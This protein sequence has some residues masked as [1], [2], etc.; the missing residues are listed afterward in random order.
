MNGDYVNGRRIEEKERKF[1]LLCVCVCVCERMFVLVI[2]SRERR[3]T[4]A[5]DPERL[6]IGTAKMNEK[7]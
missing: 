2:V 3:G 1:R 4:E 6:G 5:T 7:Y